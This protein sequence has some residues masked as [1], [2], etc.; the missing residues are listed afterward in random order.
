MMKEIMEQP[1]VIAATIH[2]RISDGLPSLANDN[3]PDDIFKGLKSI[4]IVACGTAMHAGMVFKAMV[5]PLIRIPVTVNIASEF[6]YQD[7]IIDN[8]TLVI[9]I[10]QSGETIDTLEALRPSSMFKVPALPAKAIMLSIRMQV[11]RSP[12][13]AQRLTP[14]RSRP[15]I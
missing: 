3:V 9:A 1:D 5:E 11:R 4:Q 15:C 13:P 10:S 7:P 8:H 12:W 2:G 6:R 14:C